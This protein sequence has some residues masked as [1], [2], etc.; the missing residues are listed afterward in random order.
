MTKLE[1]HLEGIINVFH[2]YSSRVGDPDTLSKGELKQLITRELKNSLENT[3]DQ[4]TIDKIFQ[5]LD[6]DKDGQVTF[7]EFVVLVSRVLRTAHVN[8]HKE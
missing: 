2:R 8:I 5:D 6:A 7:D 1:E 4:A 3:K